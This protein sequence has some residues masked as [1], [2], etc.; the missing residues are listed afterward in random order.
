MA[1]RSSSLTQTRP[2][3][4]WGFP[5]GRPGS[6]SLRW[7]RVAALFVPLLVALVTGCTPAAQVTPASALTPA[8]PDLLVGTT[9]T[10][11]DTGLLDVLVPMFEKETGYK[12][13]TIVAGSGAI[14]ATGSR[15]EVD[16]LLTHSPAAEKK[17]V[18]DGYAVNRRL[19]MHNDFVVV[20]PTNDPARIRGT[21]VAAE[22]FAKLAG[23][24]A[25]FISRGDNS[26]THVVELAVWKVAGISPKGASWYQETGTGQG[27][28]LN[29]AAEKKAYVLADRGTY[30]ANRQNLKDMQILVQGDPILLN[31]YH[32]MEVNAAQF[33]RVNGVGAKAFA[34]FMVAPGTQA[35]IGTFG[36]EKYGQALFF[37]DATKTDAELG[38]E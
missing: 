9:T 34:D 33:Q 20:G 23:A 14:L 5:S 19:V 1:S 8:N 16:V 21:K 35:V 17:A 6:S 26:G 11:Q 28:T 13:K 7:A 30:L 22:A 24:N 18:Q 15:G 27:A 4:T 32:V 12:V 36:V 37:P 25:L 10:T 38:L 31:V 2:T 29:V 3:R